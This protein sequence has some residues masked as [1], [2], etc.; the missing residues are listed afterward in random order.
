MNSKKAQFMIVT[1]VLV[2]ITFFVMFALIRSIDR[3]SIV[4]FTR[5]SPEDFEN[6]QNAIAKR[7]SW[8]GSYWGDLNWEERAVIEVT[9]SIVNPVQVNPGILPGFNCNNEVRVLNSAGIEIASNVNL[10]ASPCEVIFEATTPG[11]YDIY[12]NNPS[13]T[14]PLYR[15]SLPPFGNP[16][17]FT[18]VRKETSPKS[19]FCPH[20]KQVNPISGANLNCE[21]ASLIGNT[22]AKYNLDFNS[23][24]FKFKGSAS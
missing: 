3:S 1:I 15:S 13:A 8:T 20:L 17:A 11:R 18:I 4:F 22:K 5:D 6:L 16:P 23:L 24:T 2:S 14:P 7:N 10:I 12:W 21:V 19:K 9:G